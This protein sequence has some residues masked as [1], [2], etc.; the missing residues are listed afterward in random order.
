MLGIEGSPF[1]P[2]PEGTFVFLDTASR[3]RLLLI[4][5]GGASEAR[6]EEHSDQISI[7]T[8]KRLIRTSAL[9]CLAPI[10]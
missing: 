3:S 2:Q 6:I 1:D 7:T 10:A 8:V 4:I 9:L 5:R